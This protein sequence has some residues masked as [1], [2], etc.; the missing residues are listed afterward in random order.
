MR[1]QVLFVHVHELYGKVNPFTGRVRLFLPDDIL[2]TKNGD[3]VLHQQIAPPPG[4]LQD[5]ASDDQTFLG[6]QADLKGHRLTRQGEQL[7]LA[8]RNASVHIAGKFL[9]GPGACCH[10]LR[11]PGN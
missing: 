9:P 3:L 6:F 5:G 4:V 8:R 10:G 2:F 11:F 7:G 1:H